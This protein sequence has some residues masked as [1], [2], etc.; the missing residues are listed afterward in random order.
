MSIQNTAAA[1]LLVDVVREL[2]EQGWKLA[3]GQDSA[4][5]SI[6]K[7]VEKAVGKAFDVI[8]AELQREFA[9]RQLTFDLA[10]FL[11]KPKAVLDAMTPSGPGIVARA[12]DGV[13]IVELGPD[14]EF[15]PKTVVAVDDRFDEGKER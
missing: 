4:K 11:D 3:T 14:E 8:R 2:A 7:I 13:Q 9:I 1:S 6:E 5:E 10:V 15:E 12:L